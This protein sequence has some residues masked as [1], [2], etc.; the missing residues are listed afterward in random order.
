M[1][2]IKTVAACAGAL[3]LVGCAGV[4]KA[5]EPNMTHLIPVNTAMPPELTPETEIKDTPHIDPADDTAPPKRRIRHHRPIVAPVA[6]AA[7]PVSPPSA[8]TPTP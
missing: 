8:M 2:L 7:L 3:A 5:P 6:P 1:K 4:K